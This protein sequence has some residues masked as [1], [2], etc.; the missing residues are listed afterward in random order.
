MKLYKVDQKK[1]QE[2]SKDAQL[3]NI[4][5]E[6]SRA[7]HASL[8][9]EEELVNGAYERAISMIDASLE[10]PRWAD[11]SLF[12]ELRDAIAALYARKV[13]PAISNFI[14]SQLLLTSSTAKPAV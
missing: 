10:D 5:A 4:A 7:T 6:I 9:G 1:W 8:R 2:F 13:D 3:K 12:Y 14:Y 11:K